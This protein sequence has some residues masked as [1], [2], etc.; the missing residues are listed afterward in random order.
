MKRSKMVDILRDA[1]L[2]HMNCSYD[3]CGDDPKMYSTILRA[4][5][6]SGMLPPFNLDAYLRSNR[7]PGDGHIWEGE[8]E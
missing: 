3:C 8:D 5:E 7:A 2:E 1:V 6:E 4:L